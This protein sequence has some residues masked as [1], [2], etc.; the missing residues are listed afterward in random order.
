MVRLV[1]GDGTGEV[2]PSFLILFGG[3]SPGTKPGVD[4]SRD[5]GLGV[6]LDEAVEFGLEGCFVLLGEVDE[7]EVEGGVFSES[8]R[9]EFTGFG[10]VREGLRKLFLFEVGPA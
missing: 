1:K 6:V 10:E 8:L 5:A 2:F 4:R 7:G 9:I 3:G